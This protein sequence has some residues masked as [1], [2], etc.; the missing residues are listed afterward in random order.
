[1]LSNPV[2]DGGE[3]EQ[4]KGDVRKRASA[5]RKREGSAMGADPAWAAALRGGGLEEQHLWACSICGT[6]GEISQRNACKSE[7]RREFRE[8]GNYRYETH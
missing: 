2:R 5:E 8:V 3:E 4:T 1:M 7:P 6:S